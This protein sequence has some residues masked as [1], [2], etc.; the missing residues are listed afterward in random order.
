MWQSASATSSGSRSGLGTAR[1]PVP[2]QGQAWRPRRRFVDSNCQ[3]SG[4]VGPAA[5][6]P[7]S[8][9]TK[10]RGILMPLGAL[11]SGGADWLDVPVWVDLD[12]IYGPPPED[13]QPWP[14][15]NLVHGL[16]LSGTVPGRLRQWG[17]A[18]DGLWVGLVDFTVCD[19][20][21]ATV[22]RMKRV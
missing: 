8:D 16:V 14:G 2:D 21:G 13:V 12:Q 20:H 19:L 11:S 17:R 7:R 18:V 9:R 10:I 3:C 6:P 22:A 4:S 1:S 15:G 5:L